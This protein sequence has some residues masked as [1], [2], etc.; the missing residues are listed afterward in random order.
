MAA[1]YAPLDETTAKKSVTIPRPLDGETEARTGAHAL[2]L[3]RTR[4]IVEAYEDAHGPFTP[5]EIEEARR[6]W[7]GE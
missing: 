1:E 2:A 5:E 6:T 3:A 4:E 7:H